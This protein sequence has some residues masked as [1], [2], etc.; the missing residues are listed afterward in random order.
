M[1]RSENL[2]PDDGTHARF[3]SQTQWTMLIRPAADPSSPKA[4]EALNQLCRVYWF[5]VY[6]FIRSERIETHQAKDLTQGFFVH[7]LEGNLIQQAS[8]E[9][10]RFRTFLLAC[11]R[12]FM[13]DQWRHEQAIKRG[14]GAMV[15]SIDDTEAEEKYQQ[16][17]ANQPAPDIAFDRT[18]A[19]TVIEQAMQRLKQTYADRGRLDVFEATKGCLSGEV[20]PDT[21]PGLAAKLGMS[22][23]TFEVNLSRF[24]KAFGGLVRRVIAETVEPAEIN[25]E[26]KYLLAA[27]SAWLN[28]KL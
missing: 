12:N 15:V 4:Q 9:K 3:P 21:Y 1:N 23:E 22:K 19:A 24:R 5:P 2:Q 20:S 8:R 25:G 10:G 17:P 16:L 26:I 27:W 6:A 18:W 13:N 7:L 11:L 14:G 28:E